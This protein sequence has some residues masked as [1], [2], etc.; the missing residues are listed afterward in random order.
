MSSLDPHRAVLISYQAMGFCNPLSAELLDRTVKMAAL[1]PGSRVLDLGCGNAAMAIHLAEN[2]GLKV[3]A[4]E[5]SPAVAAIARERLRGRGAPGAV[6]LHNVS[7]K[8]FLDGGKAYD[9]L[10]AVGASGVVEGPPEPLAILKALRPHVRPGGY[11]L[12]ADAFWK[13]EPDPM[14]LAMLGGLAAYKSH[15]ENVADGEAAGLTAYYAGVSADQDWD[16]YTWRM[17]AAIERWLADNPDDPEAESVRQRGAFMRAA[18][19]A[20]G[21]DS[22]G[23]GVY[24]FRAP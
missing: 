16:D 6:T 14:F 3:D 20:Q 2:H 19:L 18:Y 17:A 15:A 23:F 5:R 1:E 7:S 10:L 13:R 9:L 24:L 22:M 21:R 11:L 8:D 4:I 12:W